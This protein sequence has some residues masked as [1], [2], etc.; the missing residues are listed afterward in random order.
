MESVRMP[1]L[2]ASHFKTFE[3]VHPYNGGS[4]ESI[5]DFWERA[6]DPSRKPYPHNKNRHMNDDGIFSVSDPWYDYDDFA[7]IV[8]QFT[9]L[10]RTRFKFEWKGKTYNFNVHYARNGSQSEEE[11]FN[12]FLEWLLDRE[13]TYEQWQELHDRQT[14][15]RV[16]KFLQNFEMHGVRALVTV[17]PYDGLKYVE[18]DPW[19]K[20]RLVQFKYLNKYYPTYNTL[21]EVPEMKIDTDTR[22]FKVTP[23]DHH[24]SLMAHQVVADALIQKIDSSYIHR[25]RQ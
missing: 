14:T 15:A 10:E 24:P 19:L 16:K 4:D 7:Y 5:L 6:F 22:H 25:P 11:G 21:M 8:Y 9:Q 23:G 17:W 12:A 18:E 13:M 3:A 20:E 1:R 2:V